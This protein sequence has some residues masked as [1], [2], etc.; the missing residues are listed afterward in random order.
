M[1]E[2]GFFR[3][4]QQWKSQ[5][6]LNVETSNVIFHPA[7]TD[8]GKQLRLIDLTKRDLAILQ[9]LHPYVEEQVADIVRAFYIPVFATPQLKEIIEAHSTPA[10]LEET[11]K[12]HIA[13]MFLGEMDDAYF[14]KRKKIAKMHYR[15]GLSSK[16]YIGSFQSILSSLIELCEKMFQ[17]KDERMQAIQ[18]VTRII[19]LEQQ[20]VLEAYDDETIIAINR[21]QEKLKKQ[22]KQQLSA[23]TQALTNLSDE[24]VVSF[25]QLLEKSKKVSTTVMASFETTEETKH[26]AQ[27]GGKQILELSN[28]MQTLE[29]SSDTMIDLTQKLIASSVEITR[30][31]GLVKSIAEQTNL[32]ALNSAIEAARAGEHGKGFAVVADEVRK[33]SDQ[34]KTSVE[35]IGKLIQNSSSYIAQA[36]EA[37]QQV[38]SLVSKG[39]KQTTHTQK[40]FYDIAMTLHNSSQVVSE[41]QNE[42]SV[43][44][45]IIDDISHVSQEVSEQAEY[46]M[47]ATQSL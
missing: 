18:A 22:L 14:E 10:R 30:V 2:T 45:S 7:S 33:L 20:L 4:R 17:D 9:Q 12:V 8:V 44:M 25:A 16:W 21:G 27:D 24:T 1:F 47:E 38:S 19:N 43:L 6:N 29:D 39:E 13:E 32:L 23:V 37:I 5:I 41:M 34:T 36:N 26:K 15:I 11:L 46:L 40:S 31:I 35:T 28:M 42:F 3:K